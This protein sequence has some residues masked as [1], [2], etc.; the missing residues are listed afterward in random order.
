MASL[1]KNTDTLQL[2]DFN[3]RLTERACVRV[4]SSTFFSHRKLLYRPK[5]KTV[6]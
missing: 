3:Y 1:L 5:I 2:L 4:C 6:F